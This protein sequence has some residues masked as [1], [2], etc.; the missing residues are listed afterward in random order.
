MDAGFK[1]S[2]KKR[3]TLDVPTVGKS[4]SRGGAFARIH[5]NK[6]HLGLCE[7]QIN[8]EFKNGGER[9][10]SNPL[11]TEA[12]FAEFSKNRGARLGL[13]DEEHK[14]IGQTYSCIRQSRLNTEAERRNCVRESFRG[15]EKERD[16]AALNA[17]LYP[18]ARRTVFLDKEVVK[19]SNKAEQDARGEKSGLG[20]EGCGH[21]EPKKVPSAQDVYQKLIASPTQ[22]RRPTLTQKR[23]IRG[24]KNDKPT[25]RKDLIKSALC[26]KHF[27]GETT[28]QS[29]YKRYTNSLYSP[30]ARQRPIWADR[31]VASIGSGHWYLPFNHQ[32]GIDTDYRIQYVSDDQIQKQQSA[33]RRTIVEKNGKLAFRSEYTAQFQPQISMLTLN[34]K[35]VE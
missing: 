5:M 4:P 11:R 28:C 10:A 7:P 8:P 26:S 31:V 23:I 33:R 22:A 34:T 32:S 29:S 21:I 24:Q 1:G 19:E 13:T 14:K 9:R 16:W 17:S 35:D 15:F 12:S 20:D 6:G 25:G 18:S 2:S 3:S 27:Y 30:N